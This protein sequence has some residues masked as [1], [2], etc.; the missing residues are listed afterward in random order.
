MDFKASAIE[1]FDVGQ[2]RIF[3]H[4]QSKKIIFVLSLSKRVHPE[5]NQ[6]LKPLGEN[7]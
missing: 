4:L 7:W 1:A 2:V 5:S 6:M 3:R